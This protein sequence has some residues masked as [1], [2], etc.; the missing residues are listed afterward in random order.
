MLSWLCTRLL[1]RALEVRE[2]FSC[3]GEMR[4]A[5]CV[6]GA[7]DRKYRMHRFFTT[8]FCLNN[9]FELWID[10]HWFPNIFHV[11]YV[12]RFKWW[13]YGIKKSAGHFW[14]FL[15]AFCCCPKVFKKETTRCGCGIRGSFKIR[16]RSWERMYL[17]SRVW[18]YL[19]WSPKQICWNVYNRD[20]L[21]FRNK[22]ILSSSRRTVVFSSYFVITAITKK[23]QMIVAHFDKN[24]SL[25]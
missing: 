15:L 3:T 10:F 4:T 13:A 17:E 11:C 9:C 7:R 20:S 16:V 6:V 23:R 24:L 22:F 25:S 14:R 1:Q 18:R 2:I 21:I 8:S 19:G 5:A 12:K